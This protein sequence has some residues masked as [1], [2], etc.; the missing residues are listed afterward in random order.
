LA[1][2]VLVGSAPGHH[3]FATLHP[4]GGDRFVCEV[5]LADDKAQGQW[6]ATLYLSEDGGATWRRGRDIPSYGPISMP[7]GPQE[8]LLMPYEQWPLQAG[9]KRNV[10]APGTILRWPE[11]GEITAETAP[12]RFLGF[13]QDLADYRDDG[14]FVVT[15]GNILP[16]TDGRMWMAMYGKFAA[17]EAYKVC[18]VASE[19]GG[20]TWRFLSIV[21]DGADIAG[22]SEGA[23]ESHTARLA[24]GRLLCVYRTGSGRDQLYHKSYSSDDG[25]IWTA[26]EPV[27]GAWSVEPQ[28]VRLENGL[29][30][31]SGGRWG[32]FMWLCTDG[33]GNTW[34]PVN[35][36]EHH[37][38]CLD[39]PH[40][41]YTDET[42]RAEVAPSQY[43]TTSYT[44]MI[45]VGPDEVMI[46]YDR[47]AVG[48]S[49]GP[50]AAGELDA[51]FTVRA[52]IT[53][54]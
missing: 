14:L 46:C 38:V 13:P 21:A 32:L 52:R 4:F 22:A 23:D 16:L 2:P 12:V 19:D 28:L 3:W 9:D 17:D 48:W 29:L 51:V 7:R 11:G 36:A 37:N 40:L 26:P 49:G 5:V 44:G 54:A 45:A 42:V 25:L 33:E 31:L 27:A 50:S 34:Q 15:N 1:A 6:P 30:V 35:L 39:E 47:L 8:R 10:T 20:L 53:P 24:D 18:G 43:Q 41:R